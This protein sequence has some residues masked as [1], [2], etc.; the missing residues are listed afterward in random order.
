MKGDFSR[1]NFR[2]K[3]HYLRVLQQQGRPALDADWNEQVAILL[4]R[5]ALLTGDVTGGGI[6]RAAGP[7][8]FAGFAIDALGE[9]TPNDFSISAGRYYVDG[10]CCECEAETTYQEQPLPPDPTPDADGIHLAYL[11]AW[12]AVVGPSDDPVLSEPALSGIETTLRSRVVWQVRTHR[13]SQRHDQGAPDF[14]ALRSE[15][16]EI[17]TRMRTQRRGMLKVRL[18]GSVNETARRPGTTRGGQFRGVENLL[19]R[20]EVHEGGP[21]GRATFKWSRDNGAALLPLESLAGQVAQVTHR[22]RQDLARLRKDTWVEA[23]NSHDRLVGRRQALVQVKSADAATGEIQLSA[24]PAGHDGKA[25]DLALRRW[26]Q[27]ENAGPSGIAIVEGEDDAHWLDLEDGI[28]IQ[29][30]AGNQHRHEYRTG[31]YW[32]IPARTA[33]EGILLRNRTPQPPDGVQHVYAPLRLVVPRTGEALWNYRRTFHSL[34]ALQEQ[35]ARLHD[36]VHTL[37]ET[38]EDLQRRLASA[39]RT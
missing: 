24:A 35:I 7:E 38:V 12:E 15:A 1:L 37:T 19:Y 30:Q 8:G 2:P 3:Q 28:Q 29:F 6:S 33:D 39:G 9:K 21:I 10:L 22:A 5:L 36:R 14:E 26:D 13:L 17:L 18:A 4:H 20:V 31:D 23:S 25:R 16:Q 27:L 34:E 11:D 32:L